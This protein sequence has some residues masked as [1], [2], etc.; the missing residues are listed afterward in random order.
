MEG[1]E[2]R[3]IIKVCITCMRYTVRPWD[4]EVRNG[5]GSS[6]A[7]EGAPRKNEKES[8]VNELQRILR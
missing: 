2:S 1:A 8:G 3:R 5:D 6:F 4:L 7:L